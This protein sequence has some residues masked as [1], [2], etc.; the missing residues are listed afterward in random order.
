METAGEGYA[1]HSERGRVVEGLVRA[2][3]HLVQEVFSNPILA[4]WTHLP[5][6][7]RPARAIRASLSF[8]RCPGRPAASG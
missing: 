8:V 7:D 6:V 5:D 4:A 2:P 3:A 1:E